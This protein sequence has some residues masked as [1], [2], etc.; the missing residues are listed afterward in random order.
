MDEIGLTDTEQKLALVQP[1]FACAA[2]TSRMDGFIHGEE[3][4]FV[5]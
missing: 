3:I 4:M 2:V 1:G 5:E